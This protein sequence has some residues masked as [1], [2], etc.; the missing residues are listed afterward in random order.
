MDEVRHIYRSMVFPFP[1]VYSW[2]LD[3]GAELNLADAYN[4]LFV[5]TG[6]TLM[7][8]KSMKEKIASLSTAKGTLFNWVSSV[9]NL[10]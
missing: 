5:K 4:A 8:R 7:S 9:T 6:L 1:L 10:E 3:F 2:V